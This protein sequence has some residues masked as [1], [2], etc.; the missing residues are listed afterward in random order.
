MSRFKQT[1]TIPRRLGDVP[2]KILTAKFVHAL[3]DGHHDLAGGRVV[4]MLCHARPVVDDP[5]SVPAQSLT[6]T[7]LS[8]QPPPPTDEQPSLRL[9]FC[10]GSSRRLVKPIVQ[11]QTSP[12]SNHADR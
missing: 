7:E 2:G 1:S 3:D 10:F 12:A 6:A 8:I 4:G 9:S 5:S 11:K